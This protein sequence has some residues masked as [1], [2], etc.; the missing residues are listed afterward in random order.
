MRCIGLLA[1][2]SLRLASIVVADELTQ[3]NAEK[4]AALSLGVI[5]PGDIGIHRM[6]RGRPL[7]QT[8]AVYLLHNAQLELYRRTVQ[9]HGDAALTV[10]NFQSR[11][12]YMSLNLDIKPFGIGENHMTLGSSFYGIYAILKTM[13]LPRSPADGFWEL[14][15]RIWNR[16]LIPGREVPLGYL[17]L[18]IGGAEAVQ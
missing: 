1:A 15:W 17:S 4:S 14:K 18:L 16:A 8:L 6:F 9:D 12:E 3:T 13:L 5:Q 2:F 10:A 7:P 11:D